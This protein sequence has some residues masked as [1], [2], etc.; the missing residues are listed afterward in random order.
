KRILFAIE[1]SGKTVFPDFK[2]G[3]HFDDKVA[4]KYLLEAIGAPLVPSYVFY[5]KKEAL[6]WVDKESLPIVAKLKGG[7]GSSNVRLIKSTKQAHR[8]INNSFNKGIK[9]FS[10]QYYAKEKL[11]HF[12]ESKNIKDL[13]KIAYRL[14]SNLT[15]KKY[16]L[17]ERNYVYF[18]KFIPNNKYDTRVIIIGDRI[19]AEKR[20]VRDNDFRASGSNKFSF[21]DI[22]LKCLRT[23]LQISKKL[24]LQS[25]AF[26]FI[27][28]NN[29]NP[30]IVEMSYGFGVKGIKNAKGYWDENLQWN[31]SNIVP[32]IWI[33][34]RILKNRIC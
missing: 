22:N 3:W 31:D 11:R 27:E 25:V 19:V 9:Q 4:Q 1:H 34:E 26:D 32:E 10:F 13:L 16:F 20:Y 17:P 29:Q 2:T 30:L 7:S 8:Y 24:N 12:K 33:L 21:D 23:A 18:Q 5:D 14:F 28:D 15:N 6:D